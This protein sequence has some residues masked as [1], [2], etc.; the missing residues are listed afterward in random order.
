MLQAPF[1]KDISCSYI[2]TGVHDV[3]H[4]ACHLMIRV[5]IVA[6][7]ANCN[8][9]WVWISEMR[10]FGW[11]KRMQT[12]CLY[13]MHSCRFKHKRCPVCLHDPTCAYRFAVSIVYK[14]TTADMSLILH[15][16]MS[17]IDLGLQHIMNG[18][19]QQKS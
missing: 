9:S 5:R 12:V 19:H 7:Q 10:R 8:M 18:K 1:A 14:I 3:K 6:T 13:D 15:D 4:F 11:Q 17:T 16:H 2:V